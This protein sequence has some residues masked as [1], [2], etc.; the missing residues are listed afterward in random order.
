MKNDPLS[1]EA[2]AAAERIAAEAP[3]MTPA[4]AARLR[5]IFR[6]ARWPEADRRA[7]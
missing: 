4:T 2:R 5:R 7:A 3:A 1:P 6:R